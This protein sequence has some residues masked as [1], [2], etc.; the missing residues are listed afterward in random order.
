MAVTKYTEKNFFELTGTRLENTS[1]LRLFDVLMDH[2]GEK[3]VN[4][5]RG[6]GVNEDALSDI[7]TYD[8]FEVSHDSKWWDSISA[9]VYGTSKLWWVV[10]MINNINNPFED[11]EVGDI[12]KVL[13]ESYLYTLFRDMER[14]AAYGE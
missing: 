12:V 2:D 7:T 10:A 13:K 8:L 5:F 3:F 4:V 9:K 11:L 14:V 6:Y 1:L